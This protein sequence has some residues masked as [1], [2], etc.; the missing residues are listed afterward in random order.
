MVCEHENVLNDF[1]PPRYLHSADSPLRVND[2]VAVAAVVVGKD[3]YYVM[4]NRYCYYDF[5]VAPAVEDVV[6]A[7]MDTLFVDF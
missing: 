6:N 1:L 2:V 4:V 7:E 3:A 5:V